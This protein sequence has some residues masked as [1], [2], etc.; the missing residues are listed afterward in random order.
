MWTNSASIWKGHR[1]V[2]CALFI[3]VIDQ[4]SGWK[5]NYYDTKTQRVFRMLHKQWIGNKSNYTH[6]A[7]NRKGKR[8]QKM[9]IQFSRVTLT[10]CGCPKQQTYFVFALVFFSFASRFST[11]FTHGEVLLS[12]RCDC[13]TFRLFVGL[14]WKIMAMLR[15]GL[16]T[17]HSFIFCSDV[18]NKKRR[19]NTH[20]KH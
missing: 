16:S 15:K 18:C 11:V 8:T 2:H 17:R 6:N 1:Y 4:S 14:S 19:K 7:P 12:Q 9:R 3:Q 20:R 13:L 5:K 10:Q